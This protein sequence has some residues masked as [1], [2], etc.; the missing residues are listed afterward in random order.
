MDTTRNRT[1]FIAPAVEPAD[2]PIIIRI[3]RI[4]WENA[5]HKLKSAVAKPVVVMIEVT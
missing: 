4:V 1:T 2:P 3:T 5:G